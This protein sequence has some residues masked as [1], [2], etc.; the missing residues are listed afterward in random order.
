MG[1]ERI[2]AFTDA[3]LAIIMTI[4]ILELEK[5][6]PLSVRGLWD[7][8]ENFFS[9]T[10][11]F[12]WLGL[13]WLTHHNSWTLVKKISNSTV[14][15]TLILL[16]F[17]SFFP[18]TTSIVSANFNSKTAQVMYGIIV[19]A[20]TLSNILISKSLDKV[21][22]HVKF[23]LLYSTSNTITIIDLIIKVAGLLIAITVFPAAMSYAIFIDIA[24]MSFSFWWLERRKEQGLT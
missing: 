16:F 23:G 1:K 7:L 24:V 22:P 3:V 10:L 4:L 21:N 9:Y 5:P 19:I 20:V 18:Y 15:Y 17:S 2:A 14:V 11:S 6:N 12:F 13:M 8:R